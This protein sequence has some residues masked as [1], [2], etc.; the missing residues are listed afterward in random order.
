MTERRR[1][2]RELSKLKSFKKALPRYID[3]SQVYG[4]NYFTPEI[5]EGVDKEISIIEAKIKAIDE[6]NPVTTK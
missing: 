5:I 4:D 3:C 6:S 1:L 2:K